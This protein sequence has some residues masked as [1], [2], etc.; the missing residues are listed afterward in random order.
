M[1]FYSENARILMKLVIKWRNWCGGGQN[2]NYIIY[3]TVLKRY[4]SWGSIVTL[5]IKGDA[6]VL[7]LCLYYRM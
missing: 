1:A 7:F 2:H 3:E 6:M 5:H 4:A